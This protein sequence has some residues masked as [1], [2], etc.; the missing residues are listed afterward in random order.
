MVKSFSNFPYTNQFKI[1]I[2]YHERKHYMLPILKFELPCTFSLSYLGMKF[3]C[4][5]N[6][7]K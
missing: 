6:Y 5:A 2:K 1:I 3:S 4:T 7:Y